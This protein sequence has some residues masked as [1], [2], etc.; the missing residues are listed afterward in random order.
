MVSETRESDWARPLLRECKE[1]QTQ[2]L[3]LLCSTGC[4]GSLA[5][6]DW[7]F[8]LIHL[9]SKARQDP[10]DSLAFLMQQFVCPEQI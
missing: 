7:G 4:T 1:S 2:H 6:G 5:F 9:Q 10:K 8:L 3:P